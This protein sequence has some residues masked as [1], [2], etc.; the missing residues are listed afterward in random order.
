ML[1]FSPTPNGDSSSAASRHS[2]AKLIQP[3]PRPR[4]GSWLMLSGRSAVHEDLDPFGVKKGWFCIHYINIIVLT[5]YYFNGSELLLLALP[6]FPFSNILTLVYS[7]QYWKKFL[8]RSFCPSFS[9][10]FLDYS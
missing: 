6:S 1:H 3:S 5:N 9:S 2:P 7:K 8:L 4:F 10:C